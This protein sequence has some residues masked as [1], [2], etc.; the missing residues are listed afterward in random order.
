MCEHRRIKSKCKECGFSTRHFLKGSFTINQL[1]E[2]GSIKICQFPNC[3]IQS[4]S[5]NSDH[6]H[7][8]QKINPNNYRG[9]ICYDHNILLAS[10]DKFPEEASINAIEYMKRRPYKQPIKE[11]I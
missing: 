11:I 5:L 7:D 4:N 9:E 3:L 1:K 10:L 8:G 6:Y 2:I